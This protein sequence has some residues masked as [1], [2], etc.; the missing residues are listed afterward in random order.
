MPRIINIKDLRERKL[1][2][3]R[4]LAK[5]AGIS[6]VTILN[7]ER[8]QSEVRFATVR[9]LAAALEVPAEELLTEDDETTPRTAA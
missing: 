8:G 7:I 1:L 2:S 4:E 5:K 3:Q 9:A 6:H